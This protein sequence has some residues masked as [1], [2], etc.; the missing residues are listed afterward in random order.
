MF[1]VII[2]TMWRSEKI[3]SSVSDFLKC[4]LISEIIII[5]N[6]VGHELEIDFDSS[7]IKL[8][9]QKE[10]IYVNPSWNLGVE[11]SIN[12][13]L[14]FVN[15]DVYIEDSCTLI[16]MFLDYDF[17]L[18]GFDKNN[19][20]VNTVFEIKDH[21]GGSPRFPQYN[22]WFYMKKNKY[23]F[24]PDNIL[25]WCGDGIQYTVNENR[26]VFTVPKVDFEMSKTLKTIPSLSWILY[27]NDRPNYIKYCNEN[28]LI[29]R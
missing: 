23:V 27:Q 13:H 9:N 12:E 21:S 7:K 26:G 14:L 16:K 19:S 4:D 18:I 28:N 6:N 2:P 1:S 8:L 24:I 17:D 11:T 25:I 5:N 29:P 22:T 15:D 3:L 20:N 10:N